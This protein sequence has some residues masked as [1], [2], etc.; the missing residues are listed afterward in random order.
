MGIQ[1]ELRAVHEAAKTCVS[2][3]VLLANLSTIWMDRPEQSNRKMVANGVGL[4]LRRLHS[5]FLQRPGDDSPVQQV[6]I[7][8]ARAAGTMMC[9]MHER[10]ALSATTHDAAFAAANRTLNAVAMNFGWLPWAGEAGIASDAI[11]DAIGDVLFL[12]AKMLADAAAALEVEFNAAAEFIEQDQGCGSA[13]EP[14]KRPKGKNV[15]ARMLEVMLVNQESHGW[16]AARWAK[17]LKCAKSSV[18]GTPAWK[19]LSLHREELRAT[20]IA[21]RRMQIPPE[22]V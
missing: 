8:G 22:L 18:V 11:M 3:L 9:R 20:K 15:N 13:N 12:D 6:L 1:E 2:E 19:S 17:R 16:T 14:P 10:T 21:K 7:R 4:S 5:A